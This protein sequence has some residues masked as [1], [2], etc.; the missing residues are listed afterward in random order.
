MYWFSKRHYP[1]GGEGE[2]GTN[3][4]SSLGTYTLP[5]I[6]REPVEICCVPQGTQT[7]AL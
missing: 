4:E 6:N 1:A 7:G 3:G 2:C 5:Y